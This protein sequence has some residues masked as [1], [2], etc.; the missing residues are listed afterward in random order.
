ML[1]LE[2]Q[3]GPKIYPSRA[4][5]QILV[6]TVNACGRSPPQKNEEWKGW[7]GR[8]LLSRSPNVI[9]EFQTKI[10][11]KKASPCLHFQTNYVIPLTL[12]ARRLPPL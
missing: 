4:L 12:P 2:D 11:F 7:E 10:V 5:C 3:A 9:R 1:P 6:H 8:V